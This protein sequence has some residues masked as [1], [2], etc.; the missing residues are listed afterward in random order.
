MA[1]SISFPPAAQIE[2]LNRSNWLLWSSRILVLLCMNRLR[3]HVT[4]EKDTANKDWDQ[5]DAFGC[6]R[7][8]YS[9]G[10]LDKHL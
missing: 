1:P 5:G 9:E 8:V 6:P 2:I 4:A 7:D 10:R 3:K